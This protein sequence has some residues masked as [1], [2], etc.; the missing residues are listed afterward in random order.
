MKRLIMFAVL[1]AFALGAAATAKAKA[2]PGQDV[3]LYNALITMPNDTGVQAEVTALP[4]ACATDYI[5]TGQFDP[6]LAVAGIDYNGNLGNDAGIM[7]AMHM[8]IETPEQTVVAFYDSTQFTVPARDAP[9][10]GNCASCHQQA[11]ENGA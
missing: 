2:P 5:A 6:G 7:T 9:M 8:P 3:I 4:A 11:L 1:C 10:A